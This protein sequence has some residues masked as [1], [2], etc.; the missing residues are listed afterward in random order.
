MN[1]MTLYPVLNR[2]SSIRR[3]VSEGTIC[4]SLNLLYPQ[5][6]PH[7]HLHQAGSMVSVHRPNYTKRKSSG[8]WYLAKRVSTK[9]LQIITFALGRRFLTTSAEESFFSDPFE[10]VQ[11]CKLVFAIVIMTAPKE[12]SRILHPPLP[13]YFTT[14][15]HSW[16]LVKRQWS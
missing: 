8:S 11:W 4:E 7:F 1:D 13:R 9:C 16:S 12:P 14:T 3:K 5:I 10:H 2:K 6:L 15:Y